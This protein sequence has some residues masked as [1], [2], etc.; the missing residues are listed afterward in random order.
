MPLLTPDE[1]LDLDFG[2]GWTGK[3]VHSEKMSFM[4]YR[5]AADAQPIP[6]HQ[7]P[8][9]EVWI[10][11]EGEME[12]TVEGTTQVLGPGG[13]A[14]VPCNARHALRPRGEVRSIVVNHPLRESL[15]GE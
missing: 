14:I 13:V 8:Q 5:A 2:T 15:S 9:E 4:Q 12:I 10:L 6:D 1:L 7:H 11:I 3:F